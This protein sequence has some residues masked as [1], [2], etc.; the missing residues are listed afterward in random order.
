MSLK[1]NT[2]T[3]DSPKLVP[4]KPILRKI[5][6]FNKIIRS[7]SEIMSSGRSLTFSEIEK[8]YNFL[9]ENALNISISQKDLSKMSSFRTNT[10]IGKINSNRTN[11]FRQNS[12][13]A[14]TYQKI[15]VF[16]TKQS[17]Q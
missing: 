16:E 13:K 5:Q 17:D 12:K 11:D 10:I 1:T 2:E 8:N 6:E 14:E 7:R 3:I 9:I 4:G 15:P